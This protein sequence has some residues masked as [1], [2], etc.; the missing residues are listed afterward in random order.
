[1]SG[2]T[3]S[4]SRQWTGVD[5]IDVKRLFTLFFTRKIDGGRGVGLY[6]CQANLA[7]GGHQISYVR[8]LE[9]RTLPGAN[10][11]IKFRGATFNA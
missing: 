5:N 10:F 4:S 2:V 6:L 9:E 1:M 3:P 8:D 11:V 7:A